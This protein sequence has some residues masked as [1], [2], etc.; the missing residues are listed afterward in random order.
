MSINR[1]RTSGFVLNERVASGDLT[2]IDINAASA[3]DKRSGQTD[4]VASTITLTGQISAATIGQ[5]RN[6]GYEYYGPNCDIY[7]ATGNQI[8]GYQFFHGPGGGSIYGA[9][10][11]LALN[12]GSNLTISSYTTASYLSGSVHT[13]NNNTRAVWNAGAY[14]TWSQVNYTFP[15]NAD[16]TLSDQDSMCQILVVQNGV[17]NARRTITSSQNPGVG[18]VRFVINQNLYPIDYKATGS[19]NPL[20]IPPLSQA[21]IG[22]TAAFTLVFLQRPTPIMGDGDKLQAGGSGTNNAQDM[23]FGCLDY[24]FPSDADQTLVYRQATMRQMIV[25]TGTIS[26]TRKLTSPLAPFY[27]YELLLKNENAQSVQ[28]A[29]TTGSAITV[30]TAKS[31]IIGS[32][33]TNAIILLG[34]I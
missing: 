31:A 24:T 34:P 5:I 33:G 19:S 12:T 9:N 30:P 20:S 13:W 32:D 28:F 26:A 17:I 4:T 3:V 29:F 10:S 8:D 1:V 27:G 22:S 15:S 11:A 7:Y 23:V 25:R 14:Q 21:V 6:D 16:Q 18:Y 2:Q